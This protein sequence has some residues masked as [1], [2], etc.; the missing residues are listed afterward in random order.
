LQHGSEGFHSCSQCFSAVIPCIPQVSL[1]G[2][3]VYLESDGQELACLTDVDPVVAQGFSRDPGKGF[4]LDQHRVSGNLFYVTFSRIPSLETLSDRVRDGD[5]MWKS[6]TS[7][8]S[9]EKD[10]LDDMF[11]PARTPRTGDVTGV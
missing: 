5:R 9:S 10:G 11:G 3:F 7:Q 8:W 2:H 1:L 6:C 4:A